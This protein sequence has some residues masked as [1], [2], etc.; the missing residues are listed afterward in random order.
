MSLQARRWRRAIDVVACEGIKF[1]KLRVWQSLFLVLSSG[2]SMTGA[3]SGRPDPKVVDGAR[4]EGEIVWYT[5][6]SVDQSKEFMDTIPAKVPVSAAVDDSRSAARRYSIASRRKR[7][8]EDTCFD[9][10][11]GTGRNMFCR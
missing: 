11:H 6:M 7:R 9:V 4:K 1:L 5:T 8:R 10:V 3:R 2:V